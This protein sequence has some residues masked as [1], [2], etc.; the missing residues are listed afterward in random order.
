MVNTAVEVVAQHQWQCALNLAGGSDDKVAGGGCGANVA[1]ALVVEARAKHCHLV[2]AHKWVKLQVKPL[3]QSRCQFLAQRLKVGYHLSEAVVERGFLLHDDVLVLEHVVIDALDGGAQRGECVEE[4]EHVVDEV[5]VALPQVA[6]VAVE[7]RDALLHLNV[8]DGEFALARHG[9]GERRWRRG[10][11][12]LAVPQQ[13]VP[14]GEH[15][16]VILGVAG[17]EKL[18]RFA[19]EAMLGIALEALQLLLA[20]PAHDVQIV[21]VILE[22]EEQ[23][24]HI[25]RVRHQ[26]LVHHGAAQAS[27]SGQML[28]CVLHQVE[29]RKWTGDGCARILAQASVGV[30]DLLDIIVDIGRYRNPVLRASLGGLVIVG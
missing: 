24:S 13:D 8:M 23:L 18:Q 30:L 21:F 14:V 2:V 27:V 6:S 22:V 26:S 1:S 17:E 10:A 19:I 11:Y 7:K 3:H 4:H 16:E 5:L 20:V 12:H 29:L 25:E 15:V 9:N 28:K